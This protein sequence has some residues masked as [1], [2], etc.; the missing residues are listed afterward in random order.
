MLK[1][2]RL[3]KQL[4]FLFLF[5]CSVLF[6]NDLSAASINFSQL[7]KA[8]ANTSTGSLGLY[9]VEDNSLISIN[10]IVGT[11]FKF[12]S[13]NPADVT[14][15]GNNIQG[16]LTYNNSTG[17][18]IS[19]IG[20]ISRPD[21]SG[22]TPLAVNFIVTTDRTVTGEGYALIIASHESS[23]TNGMNFTTSSDPIATVLNNIL[24]SPSIINTGTL[25]AM[26]ACSGS[27]SAAQSFT[28]SATYL[29]ANL[30]VTAPTGYEVSKTSA[31]GFGSS[32]SFTPISGTVSSSTV[33]IRLKTTALNGAT[34]DVTCTSTKAAT[35]YI[36]TGVAV[37]SSS[38]TITISPITAV[39][40]TATSFAIAF[41]G[42]TGSPNQYSLS[43]STPALTG[44]SN[45]AI[46][47][48]PSSP[49]SVTIPASS[50]GSYGFNLTLVNSVNTCSKVYPI[51]LTISDI[52][53]GSIGSDQ[54]IC[55]NTTPSTLTSTT[56][57]TG[58]TG[59][60]TYEWY[61]ST[62][63]ISDG[64]TA[65]ASSNTLTY[66]PGT[67][68][69][70]SYFYRKATDQSGTPKTGNSNVI[71][72]TVNPVPTIDSTIDGS[73]CGTGT[74]DLGAIA[75][76]GIL[77]WYAAS[78]G[79]TSLGTGSTYTT[80][81]ISATT[82]YYV[83]ATSGSCTSATRTSV[84]AT[85]NEIPTVSGTT[86]AARCGTGIVNIKAKASAGTLNWYAALTGGTSLGTD[87]VFTTPSISATTTYYVDATNGTCTTATRTAVVATINEIPNVSGTTPA[88]RCG[89][90][91][92]D[93]GATAS[94]GTLNWYAAST[95]GTSLGTGTTFTTPSISTTTTYYVDATSGSCTTASRT[96]VVATISICIVANPDINATIVNTPVS[97]NVNTN[98]KT[99]TGTTYKTPTA[100]TT[101]PSGAKITLDSTGAYT[102]T[103]S[104]PGKYIYYVAV[105][106]A[107]Q[108]TGCAITTL[109]I[110]VTDPSITTNPPLA[111]ND[112]STSQ[113]NT[114][115]VVKILS[116]DKVA[117]PNTTLLPST[118][119]I[120]DTPMNGTATV[121]KTTGV[122]TFTPTTGFVGTDSLNYNVCDNSSPSN[123]QV[124]TVY[125]KISSSAVAEYSTADDDFNTVNMNASVTGNV[126]SNDINSADKALTVTSN[127]TP[128]TTQGTININADGSYTFTPTTNFY[129]PVDITYNACTAG[130][131]CATATLH[132]LVVPVKPA[133]PKPIHGTYTTGVSTNP[134]NIAPT[135]T[136]IPSGC[137]VIYCD[138]NGLSCSTTVPTLPTVPG[139]Y[140]WCVKSLDT[141]TG[142]T[143][144]P[145]VYDT[146]RILPKLTTKNATYVLGV[147]S[148]P[149]NIS[150]LVTS[151][152]AGSVPKWCDV[153]GVT[154][155]TTAPT[156]PT[157]TG[158]YIWCVKAVDI[159]SGLVSASC[160]M[161]TV[162]I[163]APY[164]ILEITKSA[165]SVKLNPN[166]S[167]LVTFAMNATNKTDVTLD[168]V[169]I[170]DNLGKT[171]NTTSGITVY[172]L[173]TFGGLVKN[174]SYDGISNIELV[175]NQSKI[176]AKSTDSLILKVLVAS[177]NI[178]GSFLNTSLL[179][180]KTKYGI[181]GVESNDPSVNAND[182][183]KRTPT[184]F[185]VPKTDIIIAGGFSPS[186]NSLNDKWI[187]IRPFGTR[188][189]V[190]VFNRWGNI[191]YQ[192]GDYKN[193]WDGR[194][195]HNFI[196]DF[197]PDG[198]Y[199]Y[200][201][202]AIDATGKVQK[203]ASSLT[204]AR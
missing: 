62:T 113:V 170:K 36:S 109:E 25:T 138:V 184:P 202:N 152:T 135:V 67:L 28:L 7:Y 23:Y 34:G 102:F 35:K 196:G 182:T 107:G 83:D 20:I 44:F 115:A 149:S 92:V 95:G 80:P 146:L 39:N 134:V 122:I 130:S 9:S 129:G 52:D 53:P 85:I 192:N 165:R 10:K 1:F 156:L 60:F 186:S 42:T 123:C 11:N 12:T 59:T 8:S 151:I 176:N 38:P 143:S 110:S 41:T 5:L 71:T 117:N 68:T 197:L 198:T 72:I 124:A 163:L 126:L 99:T 48:L 120:V 111:K 166:G 193:E 142:L 172:S 94:A 54:T 112:Y 24:T 114:P 65:I 91:T 18:L 160:V 191:V 98:D 189:E 150:G 185:V 51:S 136:N 31:S 199:F 162:K 13:A 139:I 37:I 158:T 29:T 49:I 140:V 183:T 141:L 169:T 22:S 66:S 132:I 175:T 81:S 133:P 105:C 125:F 195:Q 73:R 90:G 21:K 116:N 188:I 200:I 46:T 27:N 57:A 30:V 78:T 121:N 106:A 203:F 190:Q 173:E 82:T 64:F 88:S 147:V 69:Q 74:V 187:I 108:T 70:T 178:S 14:F 159:A 144:T 50:A 26:T 40:T 167:F 47:T 84:V 154:C 155:S 201:V 58:G 119:T 96:A 55:A 118:I 87:T 76:D 153:G 19:L 137:K 15:S 104:L 79:G 131:V 148:N 89:T 168:S 75:S 16:T 3:Y 101:N 171:F 174:S 127:S 164:S 177:T 77:N 43:A 45:V 97:G 103:A 6:I 128:L 100:S 32:V 181:L 2:K 179:S 194:G 61:I 17:T 4:S 63:S 145:C 86:A 93:L 157:I 161:D 204:I 180:G 56:T 33:Y